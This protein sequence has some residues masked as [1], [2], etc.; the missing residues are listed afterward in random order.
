MGTL[1]EIEIKRIIRKESKPSPKKTGFDD[2]LLCLGV[3]KRPKK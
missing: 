3:V 1:F 2:A